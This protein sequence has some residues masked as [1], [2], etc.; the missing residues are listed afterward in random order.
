MPV[1]P[2]CEDNNPQLGAKCPRC[3]TYY[4]YED[5]LDDAEH[6]KYIGTLAA[7]KYVILAQISEG[8]MGTIYRA[9]QLPVEREV[10][11]KV[12][13]TELEDNDEVR[14][15]FVR[16]ARAVSALSHPNIITLHDFGF[17]DQDHPYMVME[18][19]PGDNL[20]Q[21]MQRADLNIDRV[22]AV[23][24]QILSAL[25]DAHDQGIVHR[26][27]KPENM[28]VT[29]AGAQQDFIKLLDFG[30]ARLVNQEATKGLTREGEVFGTPHYMAPEQ[31]QG[32]TGIGA[33]ADVYAMGIMMYEMLSGETPFDAP[34]PLAILFKQINEEL[35]P[36]TGRNGWE[37][38]PWV[39][40]L[41]DRATQKSPEDRY[42]TAGD[43]F[44]ALEHGLDH[45][46]LPDADRDSTDDREAD[47][48]ASAPG[49]EAKNTAPANSKSAQSNSTEL[50]FDANRTGEQTQSPSEADDT[51]QRRETPGELVDVEDPNPT[52]TWFSD[53]ATALRPWYEADRNRK[54]AMFVGLI[55]LA[56]TLTLIAF[57]LTPAGGGG[58]AQADGSTAAAEGDGGP[59]ESHDTGVA[60]TSA[61][62]K[63]LAGSTH[64]E[65]TAD[66]GRDAADELAESDSADAETSGGDP[67][68]ARAG[69]SQSGDPQP[70]TGSAGSEPSGNRT[71]DDSDVAAPP[72]AETSAESTTSPP[73]DDEIRTD[74]PPDSPSTG[75]TA[76][77]DS[78]EESSED[79]SES[80]T[81]PGRF[82][83]PD[84]IPTKFG[85]P[86]E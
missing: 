84:D 64:A 11:L 26:D 80:D 45:G 40:Q 72:S 81:Q 58:P 49:A 47:D 20:G 34:T 63:R 19:A 42:Q 23:A 46:T 39:R 70:A 59:I 76:S 1:C 56:V 66:A 55:A 9:L 31:A 62:A 4:I 44:D 77:D 48:K 54:I 28:I 73:S 60:T 82:G 8:G 43:M 36:L 17:D 16:E 61:D 35:P 85:A 41:I 52:D 12:L 57:T 83:S 33:T 22:L 75:T 86:D 38:P 65:P 78:E 53:T 10:A 50:Q 18:F 2:T 5:A 51:A 7:E 69:G 71:P 30:I 32:E 29:D 74:D 27:L 6:D 14:K 13:R 15:R 37:L 67:E 21:W 3:N 79:S 24:R 25:S 68:G